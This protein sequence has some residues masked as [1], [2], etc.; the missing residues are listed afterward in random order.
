MHLFWDEGCMVQIYEVISYF[1]IFACLMIK[2]IP[3][4]LP[5]MRALDEFALGEQSPNFSPTSYH[6]PRDLWSI[7]FC[8]KRSK[9]VCGFLCSAAIRQLCKYANMRQSQVMS[10]IAPILHRSKTIRVRGTIKPTF[11]GVFLCL[12]QVWTNKKITS[13][14]NYNCIWSIMHS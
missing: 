8:S 12:Y 6:T 11:C 5:H 13:E 14:Q 7:G 1:H 10:Q 9:I 4:R 3:S 2:G